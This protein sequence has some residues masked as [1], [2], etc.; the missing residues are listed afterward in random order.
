VVKKYI[1]NAT[2]I[3]WLKLLRLPNVFTAVA[4]VMMGFLVTHGDLQP[5]WQFALLVAAS[6]LLYLSGMVLN[7]VFDAEVD[8]HEQPHRP[9]PS[10]QIPLAAA[11]AGGW[12]LLVAGVTAAGVL[13][14]SAGDARP[15]IVALMLASCVLLYNRILKRTAIAPLAMGACRMLNVLLGMSLAFLTMPT[16]N[17]DILMSRPWFAGEWLIA[18][19]IGTYIVGV[20][21]FARTDA[22]VSARTTLI[23]GLIILLAGMGLLAMT[24]VVAQQP[25]LAVGLNGWYLLWALLALVTGRRCVLAIVE[26]TATRVQAAVRHC[27]HSLIVLDAAVCLGY[28]SPFWGLAVLALIFPTVAL[29]TWLQAT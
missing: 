17:G 12:T 4:D 21:L 6:C 16:A 29:T 10:G 3:A 18:A 7:D 23:A 19:G 1:R 5:A 14:Y 25:S 26:P 2:V 24:P 9:I 22:R 27:V 15:G 20:T 28:V 11:R 13:S 8:A